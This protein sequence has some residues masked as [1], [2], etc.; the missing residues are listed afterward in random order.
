M[1]VATETTYRCEHCRKL[2]VREHFAVTHEAN[3][4]NNPVNARPCFYCPHLEKVQREY[5]F[6]TYH[7]DDVRMVGVLFCSKVDSCLYPPAVERSGQGPYELGDDSNEPMPK[8]CKYF[9]EHLKSDPFRYLAPGD[10]FH[11]ILDQL[12]QNSIED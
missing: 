10:K 2:Y 12:K 7:G 9:D 1:I 8:A 4:K 6:D 11:R 5:C 3:C